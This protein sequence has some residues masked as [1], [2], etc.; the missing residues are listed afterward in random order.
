MLR[1]TKLTKWV[2]KKKAQVSKTGALPDLVEGF[3]VFW[4]RKQAGENIQNPL[5]RWGQGSG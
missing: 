4:L 5:S 2:K 3:L 1:V